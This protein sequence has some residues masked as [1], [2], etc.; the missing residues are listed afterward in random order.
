MFLFGNEWM[1]GFSGTSMYP[2]KYL[3]SRF[4]ITDSQVHCE[5]ATG[6]EGG[7][8]GFEYGLKFTS[9]IPPPPKTNSYTDG[10]CR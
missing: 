5:T 10:L 3:C 9:H 8:T 6:R 7:C 4:L 2:T 1:K